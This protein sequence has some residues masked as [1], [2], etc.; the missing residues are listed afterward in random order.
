MTAHTI[1]YKI[2][3]Q[4]TGLYWGGRK[5]CVEK[6]GIRFVT[7]SGL[8]STMDRIIKEKGAWPSEW[9][10]E[11]VRLIEVVAETRSSNQV[12][13]DHCFAGL[14]TDAIHA[15]GVGHYYAETAGGIIDDMRRRGAFQPFMAQTDMKAGDLRKFVKDHGGDPTRVNKKSR[16]WWTVHDLSTATLLRMNGD[17][18]AMIDVNQNVATVAARLNTTP[19]G[20]IRVS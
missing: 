10:I 19:K 6:I 15:R 1:A 7:N 16:G 11:T 5:G 2:K 9:V 14:I 20:L 8:K 3:D 18:I 4:A 12:I 13:I 17:I